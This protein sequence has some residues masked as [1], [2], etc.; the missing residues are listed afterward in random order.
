MVL[1][2]YNTLTR[3]EEDFRPRHPGEP[4]AVYGCGPTVYNHPHLGNWRSFIFYD[5]LCRSLNYLG[6]KTKFA[7]NITDVDDKTIAGSQAA[8]VALQDFTKQYEDIF[9]REVAELNIWR[10]DISPRATEY[11]P[12]MI[13]LVSEL[14]AKNC[15]YPA[16]DGIY[17][18]I[19]ND[20]AYGR[21][22]NLT[23]ADNKSDF[24]LWKF[25]KTDD[26]PVVWEAPFG[27]GRPGWH[28]EC[29]AMI[30]KIFNGQL[31]I[32]LGG[33]DL[34]FPHHENEIA[35]LAALTGAPPAN[36][37]LHANFMN[38]D[39][40]KMAKSLNN[41][42][43][44]EEL[45][46]AG[47]DP[48]AYRYFVLNTHYQ[49]NLNYSL[50]GINAATNRLNR[51]R[52]QISSLPDG[53]RPNP[54]LQRQFIIGLEDNLNIPRTLAIIPSELNFRQ[55][56]SA[57]LTPADEKAT[58]LEFDK[59]WGL[60]LDIKRGEIN[61]PTKIA[62]LVAARERAREEKNWPR[63]DSLRAEIESL[64]YALKDTPDGPKLV[65]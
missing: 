56:S 29:A 59:V 63:A 26:G 21:L 27:R 20:S 62:E 64:G 1:K 28:T 46:I 12:A 4:I 49:T 8:G 52:A 54:E 33:V 38:I 14:L 18:K 16:S 57:N 5:L 58:W 61:I 42:V 13:D 10:P 44:L 31:D 6:Y 40:E 50:E 48:L 25:W 60:G 15:A 34:I 3:R 37:W 32:H 41:F 22:K 51:L 43:T 19:E 45:K 47:F 36:Y 65:K 53:G 2:F 39:D 55:H 30:K 23:A 24:A 17:F 9:W 35:Q 7:L 11:L